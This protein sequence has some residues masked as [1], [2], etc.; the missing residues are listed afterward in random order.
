MNPISLLLLLSVSQVVA[1]DQRGELVRKDMERL[2]G[3]WVAKKM[4]PEPKQEKGIRSA[5]ILTFKGNRLT[6][7]GVLSGKGT[8]LGFKRTYRITLAPLKSPKQ[9]TLTLLEGEPLLEGERR[10]EGGALVYL[11]EGATLKLAGGKELPKDFTVKPGS[12]QFLFVFKKQPP[13]R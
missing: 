5:T 7:Q 12:D 2:Q 3:T 1:D 9:I 4:V 8:A 13:P 6:W 11:I 10:G